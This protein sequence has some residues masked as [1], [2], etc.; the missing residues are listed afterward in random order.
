MCGIA[1]FS[2]FHTNY[3]EESARWFSI[4]QTMNTC[5]HHRGP[6]ENGLYLSRNCGLSHTRLSILDLAC[7]KQPMARQLGNHRAVISNNGERY[8]I[9]SH[10]RE[11]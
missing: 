5:Q 2:S 7:G 4:L 10:P 9:K 6:D 1:G 3:K 8:P 11:L